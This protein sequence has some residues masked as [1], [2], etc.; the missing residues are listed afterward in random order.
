MLSWLN[1]SGF[2]ILL[3]SIFPY[4]KKGWF[5]ISSKLFLLFGLGTNI[6]DIK[7]FASW[8]TSISLGNIKLHSNIFLNKILL[9]LSSKGRN[10]NN[11]A[12]KIIPEAHK[13]TIRPLYL[14]PLIISGAA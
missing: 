14:I 12:N 9:S 6:L 4:F 5:I 8:D 13:S 1:F 11:M 3:Y 7:S 2:I 10:P